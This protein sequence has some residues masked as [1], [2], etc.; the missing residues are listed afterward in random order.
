MMVGSISH[1]LEQSTPL[2]T[3]EEINVSTTTLTPN[4]FK[5]IA[6]P[7]NNDIKEVTSLKFE[8]SMIELGKITEMRES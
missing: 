1:L 7:K 5:I 3:L 4:E 6:I 8:Y 2:M